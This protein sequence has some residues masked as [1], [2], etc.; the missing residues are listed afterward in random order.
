MICYMMFHC[1][2]LCSRIAADFVCCSKGFQWVS[3]TWC[4][5]IICWFFLFLFH[6]LLYVDMDSNGVKWSFMMFKSFIQC[7]MICN[8]FNDFESFLKFWSLLMIRMR[9]IYL[10]VYVYIIYEY[11]YIYVYTYWYRYMISIYIY[12]YIYIHAGRV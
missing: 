10:H 3:M 12:M 7:S 6:T 5:F 4:D 2:S 9:S 11:I 1:F 8:D